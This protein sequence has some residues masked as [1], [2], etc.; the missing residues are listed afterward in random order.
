[1]FILAKVGWFDKLIATFFFNIDQV[2]YNF[3]IK[4]YDL[5]MSIARTSILTQGDIADMTGRIYR[6]LTLFMI[7]KVTLSL[8]T[9]TVSPDN[10]S[11]KSKG[12]GKLAQ[13]IVISLCVLILTP[14]IF[15]YAYKLQTMILESNALAV[16]I[17]DTDKETGGL[18]NE[19]VLNTAGENMAYTTINAFFVP[20]SSIDGLYNCANLMNVEVDPSTGDD[21]TVANPNCTGLNNADLTPA[22][23]TSDGKTMQYYATNTSNKGSFDETMLKNYVAGLNNKSLGLLFRQ[24]LA[25][26]TVTVNSEETFIMDYSYILS[27]V[28]GVLILVLLINFCIDIA[29]RSVKLAFLQIIAPI[30]I[31]TYVDPKSGK[32]GMFM[33]WAKMCGSTFVSLFIRLLAIYFAV[34]LISRIGNMVDIINGTT[35]TNNF[36]KIFI[37]IGALMFAKQLPEILKGL[38]INLE[39]GGKFTLN[40][41]RKIEKGA[42]GGGLLKKPNDALAKFGKGLAMA[43]FSGIGTLGKKTIGGIDAARSGKGFKQGWNR[44]H[45]KLYNNF[46]K[47]L[48]EWAP[49]SAEARKNARLGREEVKSMNTQWTLGK[50]L[51]DTLNKFA[52]QNGRTDGKPFA[53]LDGQNKGA[54][55]AIYTNAEFIN[56]RMNLDAMDATNKILKN[57]SEQTMRGIELNKALLSEMREI[58][59]LK[60]E[61]KEVFNKMANIQANIGADGSIIGYSVTDAEM[62]KFTKALEDTGKAVSGMEKVHESIRKQNASDA[63]REDALKFVKYN[64]IDPTEPTRKSGY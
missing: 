45:G 21:I 52:I 51:A 49:D 24:D 4:V 31:I 30:P 59:N 48:D 8:I 16:L 60:P 61:Q 29:L 54:Y 20:N 28:T 22:T 14:Y 26:A 23:G 37:I 55:E 57:I 1:M 15:N 34:Y 36:I 13:H 33:K 19:N 44:T 6:L 5:L 25:T 64:A 50:E 32:D 53:E 63:E 35:V 3:I 2:V 17:F 42:L 46:Y 43:P 27:T 12:V 18:A 41:L 39:G 9:Y 38:G 56:S 58:E 40:P 11:D 47:K 10:F 7:F 62:Q